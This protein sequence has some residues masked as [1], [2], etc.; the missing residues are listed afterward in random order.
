MSVKNP[1]ISVAWLAYYC[2]D[3]EM[4]E[5]LIPS[6]T[7]LSDRRETI[8]QKTR[9]DGLEL[10]DFNDDELLFE[11][12]DNYWNLSEESRRAQ[13]TVVSSTT[14]LVRCVIWP[15]SEYRFEGRAYL[16]D[17]RIETE[18]N[19]AN[20]LIKKVFQRAGG[21]LNRTDSAPIYSG[22]WR[23]EASTFLAEVVSCDFGLFRI[24]AILKDGQQANPGKV[25]TNELRELLDQIA[26]SGVNNT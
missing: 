24:S 7:A 15:M 5:E 26:P 16:T 2:G 23:F 1:R 21:S 6:A 14:G 9:T 11:L 10:F 20:H 19:V 18:R 22:R 3:N 17:L 25:L 8:E 4:V 12:A 13:N